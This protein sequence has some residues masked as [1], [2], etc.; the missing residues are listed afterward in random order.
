MTAD[1]GEDIR[2]RATQ[3][4]PLGRM[5]QPQDIAKTVA[6]LASADASYIT[7]QT[8]VVDGGMVM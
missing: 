2:E 4:I 5:G 6:F 3:A 7:G 1:L 8:L